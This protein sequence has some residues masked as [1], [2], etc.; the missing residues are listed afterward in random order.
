MASTD[1]K[2]DK[3]FPL[4]AHDNIF[5]RLFENPREYCQYVKNGQAVADLGCGPAYYTMALA[6]SV[7]P[8]GRVYAVDSDE[9]AIKK[10]E[11]KAQKLGIHNIE[12]HTSTASELDFVETESIDFVLAHGLLCS[13]APSQHEAAVSEMKRILKPAAQAYLTAAKGFY[14][15][16]SLDESEKILKDF[17]VESRGGDSFLSLDRWALVSKR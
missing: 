3:H 4:F 13:M 2:E 11:E 9:K 15:Y 12:T 17:R 6:E 7:G 14:S 16:M 10:V 5:R 1:N 8:Q